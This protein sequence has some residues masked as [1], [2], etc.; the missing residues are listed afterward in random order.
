MTSEHATPSAV[1]AQLT[2]RTRIC[3]F[4]D[5]VTICCAVVV[6]QYLFGRDSLATTSDPA[7]RVNC[8]AVSV[9]LAA[10]WIGLIAMGRAVPRVTDRDVT[11]YLGLAAATLQLFGVITLGSLLLHLGVGFGYLAA[12]LAFGLGA[13]L[14]TR[15]LWRRAEL[16][17]APQWQDDVTPRNP[18]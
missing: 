18:L 14:S 15:W 17:T 12:T 10:L 3:F 7:T 11:E 4:S 6:G 9:V 16:P 1:R 5:V 13:L 2:H 8:T